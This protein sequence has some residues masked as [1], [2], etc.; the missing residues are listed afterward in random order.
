MILNLEA[1][2]R[3]PSVSVTSKGVGAVLGVRRLSDQEGVT[4]VVVVTQS[5][6]SIV[7][8][9]KETGASDVAVSKLYLIGSTLAAARD[10]GPALWSV[11]AIGSDL[12]RCATA[13]RSASRKC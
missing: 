6:W 13:A 9:G 4:R 3:E 7:L 5:N 12:S 2:G 1:L 8:A 10:A 11:S